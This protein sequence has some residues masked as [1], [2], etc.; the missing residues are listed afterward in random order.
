MLS[1]ALCTYNGER[2]IGEQL[3]SLSMQTF[4]PDELVVADDGSDDRTLEIVSDFAETAPFA[5]NIIRNKEPKGVQQNFSVASAAAQGDY[6][7]FCDQ[8]DVW[9]PDK[10]SKSMTAIKQLEHLWPQQPLLVHG[11][12]LVT[13]EQL[14][15]KYRSFMSAQGLSPEAG[16]DVLLVQ[17]FVTGC[18]VMVNRKLLDMALP[19]PKYIVMHDWWLALVAAACGHIGFLHEAT[20]YYRQHSHNSVGAKKY[21]SVNS[22]EKVFA[23]KNNYIMILNVLRQVVNLQK[24]LAPSPALNLVEEYLSCV[25]SGDILGIWRLGVHKQGFWR[26]LLF[27]LYLI[28]YRRQLVL[29]VKEII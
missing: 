11:D 17:N 14:R 18:T 29:D 5:V 25:K 21:F 26:N 15:P 9:L 16:L 28:I 27:Y 23:G 13:D 24:R 6:V 10:L 19:F 2:F 4:L 7:A 20:I 8:D 3:Q 12:L 22:L 1:V